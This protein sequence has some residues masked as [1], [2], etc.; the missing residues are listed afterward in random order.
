MDST[1]D[2]DPVRGDQIFLYEVDG[3]SAGFKNPR[4]KKEQPEEEI[5]SDEAAQ[6]AEDVKPQ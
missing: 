6:P 3:V 4:R 2:F 5:K 1:N